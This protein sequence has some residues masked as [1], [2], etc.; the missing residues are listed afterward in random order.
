MYVDLYKRIVSQIWGGVNRVIRNVTFLVKTFLEIFGVS[1]IS[2]STFFLYFYS[3]KDLLDEVKKFTPKR[4]Y[5]LRSHNN[6][7]KIDGYEEYERES[8][9]LSASNIKD[10]R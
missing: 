6:R 2:L 10:E 5:Y 7:R 3:N 8:G 4:N 9:D 1:S